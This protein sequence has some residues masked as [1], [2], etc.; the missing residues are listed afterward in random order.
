M[1]TQRPGRD[2]RTPQRAARP[3]RPAARR[4]QATAP[5][6]AR[7]P[8][9]PAGTG[10]SIVVL[11]RRRTSLVV[12]V[13]LLL[14]VLAG[15][16]A[17]VQV[18]SGPA[19]AAEAR[20]DR[21]SSATLIA[22]RGQITDSQGQVLATSVQRYDIVVNQVELARW[23]ATVDEQEL[24]GAAGAAQLIAP[25]I[26]A[27]AAELG[28][29]LDGESKYRKIAKG[30][31]PEVWQS[32][33]ALRIDGISAE[34]VAERVYPNGDV[35]GNVLG[36]VNAEGVGAQGVESLLNEEL[37]GTDGSTVYER[38]AGGQQIPGGYSESTAATDGRSVQLTLNTDIQWKAQQAITAQVA[39]TGSD[40]GSIV[41]LDTRTGEIL[42]LAESAT[43]NPNDPGADATLL[44]SSS[45]VTDVFEP[46]STAK[47]I[48]MAA[49]IE[50]GLVEP[51]SE[52]EVPYQ[53]TTPN[54]QTFKDSHEHA[55]LRLTATGIL[56]ESSNTGT[57]M[58]GQNI[59]QQVRYDY[60]AKFGFGSKTGVEL[61]NESAGILHDSDAWDGRTKYADRPAP[62]QGLDR[63]RWQLHRR[64]SRRHRPGGLRD[65]RRHRAV[66]DGEHRQRRHR[67]E[68][69]DPGLPGGGQDRHRAELDRRRRG[70]HLV[71]HRRGAGG[72][73]GH[74]G[75]RHPAQP[76]HLG[77]GRHRGGAGVQR[78]GRLRPDRARHRAQRH[79]RPALPDDVVTSGTCAAPVRGAVA[80]AR[81]GRF[82]L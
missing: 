5:V 74:R 7:A 73:P 25:L 57:V 27:N 49:A 66:D 3:A 29:K 50:N 16:L 8:R 62:G 20:D 52:F 22:S 55:G 43:V 10:P 13:T 23:H 54:D 68:R 18:V 65:H 41:V 28:A 44:R 82:S 59:P 78:R 51:T 47:V 60:L 11:D 75:Q 24:S 40:S 63:G 81:R 79:D 30:V 72:R 21:L 37:T 36:W 53:Y 14:A 77:V 31:L 33:K 4:P 15:R 56:A 32:V 71:L 46:G 69:R 6:A 76:P 38:G 58:I 34:Q 35:A 45:A 12:V 9:R 67:R 42:A 80:R 64:R 19:V 1:T 2:G 26:E 17:Y 48:T 70:H 39:A 61:P